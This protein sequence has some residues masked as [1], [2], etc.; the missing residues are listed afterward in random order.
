[1][2]P[3]QNIAHSRPRDS[4]TSSVCGAVAPALHV[5]LH[6]PLRF[7]DF[8]ASAAQNGRVHV[9]PRRAPPL[10]PLVPAIL[11]RPAIGGNLCQLLG[12]VVV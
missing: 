6:L 4:Q 3:K 5:C 8:A 12:K 2:C 11:E 9:G 7:F 1:M 10:P